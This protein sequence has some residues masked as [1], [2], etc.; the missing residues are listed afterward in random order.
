MILLFIY[1]ALAASAALLLEI[2]FLSG[3]AFSLSVFIGGAIIEE[4]LKFLFL[5]G[6][7][8][9]TSYVAI[10]PLQT[11]FA[12]LC[13]GIGFATIEL[14]LAM[15]PKT[16]IALSLASLHI[17]TSLILGYAILSP[18]SRGY[19]FIFWLSV[20]IFLHVMYNAFFASLQ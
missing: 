16:T 17:A 1:G 15:P 19:M 12:L 18:K 20:A 2:L 4:G 9:R 13:F 5:L 3:L 11:F 10:V 7:Q 14:A 8:R 6:W